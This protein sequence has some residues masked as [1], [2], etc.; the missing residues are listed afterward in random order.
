MSLLSGM[1]P[2][3][4]PVPCPYPTKCIVEDK[5]NC[6]TPNSIYRWDCFLCGED[7]RPRVYIGTTSFYLHKRILEH[8]N[9]IV[10]GNMEGSAIAKHLVQEHNGMDPA[11]RCRTVA[12]EEQTL[13]R[14]VQ[15]ALILDRSRRDCILMNRRSEW[16]M[17]KLPRI[18]LARSGE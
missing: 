18:Q 8:L 5:C 4:T 6:S 7:T 17:L 14:Y 10:R 3:R 13:R 16:G 2:K 15:E 11:F 9:D 1:G 12:T